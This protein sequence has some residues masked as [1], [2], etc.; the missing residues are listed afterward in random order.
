MEED[1]KKAQIYAQKDLAE[2]YQEFSSSPIGLTAQVAA[3]RLQQNG[4]NTI[5]KIKRQPEW[6]VF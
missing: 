4:L 5:Q 6:Q 3:D 2:L 1:Q